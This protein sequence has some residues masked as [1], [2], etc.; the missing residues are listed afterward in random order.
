MYTTLSIHAGRF[1]VFPLLL[2]CPAIAAGAQSG[3]SFDEP[4]SLSVG[5]ELNFLDGFRQVDDTVALFRAPR[6]A[7]GRV[8]PRSDLV[9]R[10]QPEF[11]YFQTHSRFQTWNHMV[12]GMF[13]REVSRSLEVSIRNS[14]LSTDDPGRSLGNSLFLLP[15]GRYNENTFIANVDYAWD[16]LTTLSIRYDNIVT[17]LGLPQHERPGVFDQMGQ[18]AAFRVARRLETRHEVAVVYSY[19]TLHLLGDEGPLIETVNGFQFGQTEPAH[20]VRGEYTYS[21][22]NNLEVSTSGGVVLANAKSATASLLI[23]KRFGPLWIDGGYTRTL[24]SR[25]SELTGGST[26]S[27][28]GS[29]VLLGNLVFETATAGIS[30]A[31]NR[32]GLDLRVNGSRAETGREVNPLNFFQVRRFNDIQS[33]VVRGRFEYDLTSRFTLFTSYEYYGQNENELSLQE[34]G[35]SRQMVGLE[36]RLQSETRTPRASRSPDDAGRGSRP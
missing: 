21:L 3:F 28:S 14:L 2:A 25:G 4:A 15:R 27:P 17:R 36:F 18:S 26:G 32:F 34:L 6:I 13:T 30:G 23:R 35:R 12:E 7:Y 5:R 10:Y 33:L 19:F 9:I 16:R 20:E 22:P 24:T 8:T 11:E 31:W 1:L 29:G